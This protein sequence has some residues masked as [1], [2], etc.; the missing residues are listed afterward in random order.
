MS[1]PAQVDSVIPRGKAWFH[2]ILPALA[3]VIGVPVAPY[4][5]AFTGLAMAVSVIAGPRYS[6]FGRIFNQVIRPAFRIGK[7]HPEA[8]APHRLAEALGAMVLIAAAI[9]Y[10]IGAHGA[11]QALTL[12]VVALALLNAAAG[13]CVVCQVYPLIKRVQGKAT[14]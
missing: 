5:L 11:G 3:F 8:V 9:L 1:A 12:M 4:L 7:G 13:I 10:A 2:A 14:A 6:L